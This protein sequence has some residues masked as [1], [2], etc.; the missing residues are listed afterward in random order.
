L[1]LSQFSND[2]YARVIF[3]RLIAFEFFTLAMVGYEILETRSL[4]Q[5]AL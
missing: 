2:I 3:D 5:Q 4:I 1:L